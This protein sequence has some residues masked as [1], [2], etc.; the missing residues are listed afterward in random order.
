MDNK[1][2]KSLLS[3]NSNNGFKV[4]HNI[5]GFDYLK[6]FGLYYVSGRFTVNQIAKMIS[7]DGYTVNNSVIAL[8]VR[9]PTHNYSNKFH[10]VQ[11]NGNV[12]I[13]FQI[14]K[15][16]SGLRHRDYNRDIDTFYR[17]SDFEDMRKRDTAETIVIVQLVNDLHVT[18]PATPDY[19]Y[20]NRFNINTDLNL[21]YSGYEGKSY[22][23]NITVKDY[24]DGHQVTRSFIGR[25]FYT[26]YARDGHYK[27]DIRDIIDK[28]GYFINDRRE[29][30]KRRAA[31]LRAERKK[32]AFIAS[33]NT[34]LIEGLYQAILSRRDDIIS[35]LSN[36]TTGAD[37]ERIA[38]IFDRWNGFADIVRDY[39]R[40]KARDASKEYS[41]IDSFNKSYNGLVSRLEAILSRG[42]GKNEL[43]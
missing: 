1:D 34:R 12:D 28:S 43:I 25:T 16:E 31:A 19:N 24:S 3:N 11:Y 38:N 18:A 32:A 21:S 13:D 41:S 4:L 37:F 7:A 42:G 39:E 33:D 8:L 10:L 5:F 36:A 15:Y 20:L 26:N 22:I 30:L 35:L 40:L 2:I 17:K 23:N 14:Y 29:N 27:T 9:D 6:P